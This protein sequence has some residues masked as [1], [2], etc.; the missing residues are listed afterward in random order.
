MLCNILIVILVRWQTISR[1]FM[2]VTVGGDC[3]RV[4]VIVDA[5]DVLIVGGGE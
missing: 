2:F 4:D 1:V 5:I 3:L